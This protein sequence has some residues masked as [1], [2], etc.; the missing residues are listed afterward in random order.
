MQNEEVDRIFRVASDSFL[1]KWE[2]QKN[3]GQSLWQIRKFRETALVQEKRYRRK[4]TFW[5]FI[6]VASIPLTMVIIRY[7]DPSQEK[8][9]L[10]M[11]LAL[12]VVVPLAMVFE[13]MNENWF[14]QKDEIERCNGIL[15]RFAKSLA[16]LNPLGTGNSN[17]DVIN[18]DYVKERASTLAIRVVDAQTIF[19]SLR[20]NPEASRQMVIKAGERT[21]KFESDLERFEAALKMDFGQSLDKASIFRAAQA[22]VTKFRQNVL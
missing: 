18:E 3:G 11:A 19:D 14:K 7:F 6:M 8:A 2:A 1:T 10:S 12:C 20:K 15:E 4:R 13:R 17:I 21:G 5:F 22:Y 9:L 16:A